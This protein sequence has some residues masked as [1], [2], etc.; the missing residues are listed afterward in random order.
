MISIEGIPGIK[1]IVMDN[2]LA[3]ER[4]TAKPAEGSSFQNLLMEGI[5][6]LNTQDQE[7]AAVTQAFLKGEGPSVHT[8]MLA[9]E[10]AKL[11]MEFAVQIRNKVM[12]AYQEVMRM[13]V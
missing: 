11:S 12:E 7:S 9:T 10:Q 1:P 2:L 6:T 3:P 4:T 8:V 5:K 13:Q